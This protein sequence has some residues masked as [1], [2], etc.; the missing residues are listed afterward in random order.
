MVV[1]TLCLG[2][3]GKIT[4]TCLTVVFGLDCILRW[5]ALRLM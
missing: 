3:W 2:W 1:S 4:V 5:Q